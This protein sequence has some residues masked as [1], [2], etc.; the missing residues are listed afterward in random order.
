ML[1][2]CYH[3][4]ESPIPLLVGLTSDLGFE[5]FESPLEIQYMPD[6]EEIGICFEL[7]RKIGEKTKSNKSK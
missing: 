7:G 4:K 3:F 1:F 5:L 6:E 2:S